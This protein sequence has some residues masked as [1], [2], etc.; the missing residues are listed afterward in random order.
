MRSS[1]G[2]PHSITTTRPTHLNDLGDNGCSE[3]VSQ[4]FRCKSVGGCHVSADNQPPGR[5]RQLKADAQNRTLKSGRSP[6][7]GAFEQP[8]HQNECDER[9]ERNV[10]VRSIH[11]VAWRSILAALHRATHEFRFHCT[12]ALGRNSQHTHA[13]QAGRFPCHY[14]PMTR[15]GMKHSTHQQQQ[16]VCVS[17]H[18]TAYDLSWIAP[19]W[20]GPWETKGT[21]GQARMQKRRSAR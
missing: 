20:R 16:Q 10:Q 15:Q 6:V 11:V 9:H 1:R 18:G 7:V 17:S 3:D 14:L 21:V 4:H 5:A 19:S 12:E 13:H 2:L 8:S